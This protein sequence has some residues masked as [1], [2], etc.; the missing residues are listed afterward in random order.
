MAKEFTVLSI[1]EMVRLNDAGKTERFYRHQIK[2]T[3]G[4]VITVDISIADFNTERARPLL[5]AAAIN[6]DAIMKL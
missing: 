4:V 2:T 5:T 3:G 1:Q 6:A